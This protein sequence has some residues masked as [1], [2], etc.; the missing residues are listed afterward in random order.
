MAIKKT[1]ISDCMKLKKM[2]R[3]TFCLIGSLFQCLN[4]LKMACMATL[5]SACC[6]CFLRLLK[7]TN[8]ISLGNRHHYLPG[9]D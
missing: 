2:I 1:T 7:V 9:R 8:H 3:V 5:R 4:T 6:Q